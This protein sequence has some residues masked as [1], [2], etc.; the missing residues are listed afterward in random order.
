L[1]DF[2]SSI[3]LARTDS[4]SLE[5]SFGHPAGKVLEAIPVST[6]RLGKTKISELP[7]RDYNGRALRIDTDYFG[8]P[9]DEL[10]PV[11]GPFEEIDDAG[12][13]ARKVREKL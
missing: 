2:D 10:S 1:V 4:G 7:Y 9:R 8:N 6:D 13:F 3:Q 5:L 11:A 12:R